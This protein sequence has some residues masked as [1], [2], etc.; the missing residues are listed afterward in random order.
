[1]EANRQKLSEWNAIENIIPIIN[2]KL[3]IKISVDDIKQYEAEMPDFIFKDEKGYTI[4]VEVVECHPS[5]NTNKKRNAVERNTFKN[6]VCNIL[7][8]NSFLESMTKEKKLNIF[9]DRY[10]F[11]N[12]IDLNGDKVKLTPEAFAEEVEVYLRNMFNGFTCPTKHIKRIKVWDTCGRNIVQFN[13]IARRDSVPWQDLEKCIESKNRKYSIYQN[14]HKC[15]EYWLCI[16]LPFEE[17]KHPYELTYELL[18]EN[19]KQ[20]LDA[21]PFKCIVVTSVM[22]MDLAILKDG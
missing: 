10:N 1:M 15:D 16:Y 8:K 14:N 17:N 11:T 9:I 4:G 20:K 2:K 3:R 6:R 18:P 13:S 7:Q 19:A 21:S 5:V 22:P 12:E